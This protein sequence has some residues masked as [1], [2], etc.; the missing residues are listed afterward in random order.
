MTSVFWTA[1][2]VKWS[3]VSLSKTS[4]CL[5]VGLF[6]VQSRLSARSALPVQPG[7]VVALGCEMVTLMGFRRGHGRALP[8]LRQPGLSHCVPSPPSLAPGRSRSVTCSNDNLVRFKKANCL[9]NRFPEGRGS[10]NALDGSSNAMA[11][12]VR[13][14]L[15]NQARNH[16]H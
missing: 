1:E 5:A 4:R 12:H 15:S 7:L 11:H 13:I 14:M 2:L 16:C 9:R 6:A 3:Y 8:R 10:T